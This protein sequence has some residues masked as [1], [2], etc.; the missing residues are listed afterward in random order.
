MKSCLRTAYY[1]RV[2]TLDYDDDVIVPRGLDHADAGIGQLPRARLRVRSLH[3]VEV[4]L[5]SSTSNQLDLIMTIAEISAL[6]RRMSGYAAMLMKPI[7]TVRPTV[8]STRGLVPACY[9]S[10]NS[11]S[12]IGPKM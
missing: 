2:L 6:H 11:E 10:A 4:Y 12:E 7:G 3:P 5:A 9:L 1:R 8:S